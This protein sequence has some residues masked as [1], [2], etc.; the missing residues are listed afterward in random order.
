[1]AGWGAGA[2]RTFQPHSE[3]NFSFASI[4]VPH[5]GQKLRAIEFLRFPWERGAIATR[6][7]RWSC[8]W[9]FCSWRA[10]KTICGRNRQRAIYSI[11]D[12]V[13]VRGSG[14]QLADGNSQPLRIPQTGKRH[15][16]TSLTL[17]SRQ[18][19]STAAKTPTQ[20]NGWC[21]YLKSRT[22]PTN[23]QMTVQPFYKK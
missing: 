11:F 14:F 12:I 13:R 4:D 15:P 1:M 21:T 6:C 23:P 10:R 22:I 7:Q 16:K 5:W 8:V 20:K 18:N 17:P 9:L 3:Q 2:G 19:W